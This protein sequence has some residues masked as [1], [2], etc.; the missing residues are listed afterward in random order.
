MQ[1]RRFLFQPSQA[2]S[3]FSPTSHP[4]DFENMYKKFAL[5]L[6]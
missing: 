6:E 1:K 5:V 4:P 3:T 2:Q